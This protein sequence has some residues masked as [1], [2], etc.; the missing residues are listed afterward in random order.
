M[1]EHDTNFTGSFL[2]IQTYAR[3][4]IS[5]ARGGSIIVIGSIAGSRVL[6]PQ[7]Q[8]AYNASKAAVIHLG[9]SLA[10]EWAQHGI[11][12]NTIS[13]G[14]IDTALNSEE[15]LDEL[16]EHWRAMAPMG[17]L[18]RAKEMNELTV[19]LASEAS[20]FA[21]RRNCVSDLSFALWGSGEM[22]LILGV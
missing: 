3:H 2:I 9:K 12:V 13:P 1:M 17:R 18:G 19:L 14:Y 8:R 7:E 4:M 11:R 21:R 6:H 10:A 5:R 16:R 20:G 15:R 22:V